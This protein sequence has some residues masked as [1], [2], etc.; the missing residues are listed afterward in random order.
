MIFE[1]DCYAD[2]IWGRDRPPAIR[3]LDQGSD[4]DN[5]V[6]YCGSFSK[7]IAPAVWSRFWYSP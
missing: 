3:A 2:L 6:I 7:S 4:G 5:A 1:D